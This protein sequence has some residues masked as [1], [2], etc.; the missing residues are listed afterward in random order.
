MTN[1]GY[2]RPPREPDIEAEIYI[3][4]TDEGGR[5]TPVQ[6]GYRPSHD[7]GL[8]G[9]LNDAQHEYIGK[10]SVDLGST[11]NAFLWFLCPEYQEGR[12]YSGMEFTV[13]E[14]NKIVGKGE[15]KRVINAELAK[16]A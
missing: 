16:N 2:H 9:T 12:L 4:R 1:T 6:T 5:H 15:V 10:D 14:G 3:F 7:F 8:D 11:A 13:Q